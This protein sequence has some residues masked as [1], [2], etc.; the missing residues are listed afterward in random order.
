MKL[1]D[2]AH[3]PSPASMSYDLQ[4]RKINLFS[5]NQLGQA[6]VKKRI[7]EA[8]EVP[9]D[10]DLVDVYNLL[11]HAFALWDD[12]DLEFETEAD[13][14]SVLTLEGKPLKRVC[15]SLEEEVLGVR[16]SRSGLLP[17]QGLI[18]AVTLAMRGLDGSGNAPFFRLRPKSDSSN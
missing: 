3:T 8:F 4:V 12:P 10:N 9:T 6:R 5:G 15:E 13:P 18:V 7:A 1:R 16:A 14:E 17:Y 2:V 11:L